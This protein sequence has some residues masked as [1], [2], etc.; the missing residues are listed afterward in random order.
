MANPLSLPPPGNQVQDRPGGYD[1]DIA[2][3]PLARPGQPPMVAVVSL[4]GFTSALAVSADSG[5][6]WAV[7]QTIGIPG[8]DRPWIGMAG[9][10]DLYLEY[11]PIV[12]LA[13]AATV[14]RIERYDACVM[15]AAPGGQVAPVAQTSTLIE[16]ASQTVTNGNQ[17]PARIAV[18]RSGIYS[19][20]L[21]CDPASACRAHVAISRDRGASFT[22]V[23]L[24]DSAMNVPADGTFPLSAAADRTG[25]VTVA[26]TDKHHLRLWLSKDDG[27]TWR[28]LAQPV[29]APLG[30]SLANVPSVAVRDST[31]ALAWEGSPP[32]G[33]PQS[34]FLT[35]ARSD[36]DGKSFRFTWVPTVLATTAHD[37]P[38]ADHIYDDFG[39]Q[40]TP[41]GGISIV[42]TQSCIGHATTDAECPGPAPGQ[43]GTYDVVR[44]AWVGSAA[45]PAPPA[46]TRA[47]VAPA[48]AA[49]SRRSLPAT[50]DGDQKGRALIAVC[51][52]VA[53]VIA[54]QGARP[55]WTGARR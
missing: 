21:T 4:Y 14:P 47:V 23:D 20:Y 55:L 33:G 49:Q 54:G 16:P 15:A 10:C 24:P 41:G 45:V 35:V 7:A 6:T 11:D 38:I 31:I 46:P 44:W 27:H 29:D 2:V 43:L 12:D 52:L 40:I 48:A 36:D 19:A 37:A 17:L 32:S 39:T 8:Q 5:G 22:D 9:T 28:A 13:N 25:H 1:P 34:W 50:G 30:W 26:V 51:L 18:G 53:A 42:A 3:A